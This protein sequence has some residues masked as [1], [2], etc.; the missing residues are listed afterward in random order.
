MKFLNR[1]KD[2]FRN[3]RGVTLVEILLVVALMTILLGIAVPNLIAES[4]EIKMTEMDNNAR[5]VAVAVQSKL[6]GMKN[7]GTT[8]NSSYYKLNNLAA[9]EQKLQTTES[10]D[11]KPVNYVSNFQCDEKE[12]AADRAKYGKSML[13]S[14]AIVDPELLEKGKIVVVY[15]PTT[16]NV[17]EVYYSE[18]EFGV[19]EL[20]PRVKES[21][22]K[23]NKIGLYHGELV[24]EAEKV[25]TM[26]KIE[27]TWLW[28]DELRLEVS[29]R[30][31]LADLIADKPLGMMVYALIPARDGSPEPWEV[32]IYSQGIYKD[33]YQTA[34]VNDAR[35]KTIKA[36]YFAEGKSSAF[37]LRSIYENGGKLRFALD[38]MVVNRAQYDVQQYLRHESAPGVVSAVN[39]ELYPRESISD[40][41]NPQVNPYLTTWFRE[42][43]A[44]TTDPGPIPRGLFDNITG[45][46]PVTDYVKVNEKISLRVELHLLNDAPTF[47]VNTDGAQIYKFNDEPYGY[48]SVQSPLVSPYYYLISENVDEVALSSMRDLNNLHLVFDTGNETIK[49]AKLYADI[50]GDQFFGHLKEVRDELGKVPSVPSGVTGNWT[51]YRL[52]EATSMTAFVLTRPF[53]ISG[54]DPAGGS[55]QI[56]NISFQGR[57]G[58]DGSAEPA[59][60]FEY[61]AGCKFEDI[62]I[63]NPRSWRRNFTSPLTTGENGK[64]TEIHVSG[65]G[66]ESAGGALV[67][68]AVNCSFNN[69]RVYMNNENMIYGNNASSCAVHAS[70]LGGLVGVAIGDNS[71]DTK[72]KQT[73][74]KNCAVSAHC[75]QMSYDPAAEYIYTGGLIGIAMGDVLV[76]KSYAA[77]MLSSYYAGGLIGATVSEGKWSYD[78]GTRYENP[79]YTIE[80]R[81][82]TGTPKITNSFA[83]GQIQREV[84]VGG[85]LIAD[86]R[87]GKPEV[88]GCY[89]SVWWETISPVAYGTFEGD[90]DNYYVYQIR[91]SIP[92]TAN[93]EAWFAGTGDVL[94]LRQKETGTAAGIA[95]SGGDLADFFPEWKMTT[96]D[97]TYQWS[98]DNGGIN[99]R[100]PLR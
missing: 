63:V 53:T 7:A 84:R 61:A 93:V 40:W 4:K 10:E 85:G 99:L 1:L 47:A 36:D 72:I 44:T 70:V 62:D 97:K 8:S 21:Y 19:Q 65:K 13:L 54:T 3:R 32:C 23:E 37:T 91:Y 52:A 80:E 83:A 15:D 6:Y 56:R 28:D 55:Y 90:K 14:G 12:N 46:K 92:V 57:A 9:S 33:D 22:L 18:R 43:G 45:F 81:S 68:F 42:S 89:S 5:A 71:M 51:D 88:T 17:L 79:T 38:S 58:G 96:K 98:Y 20:F 82:V 100:S 35:Y 26:P 30:D 50:S 24:A 34:F 76:D 48:S 87:S 27:C 75:T 77:S 78:N 74:F 73:T 41:F 59:G 67:G 49:G 25:V 86:V 69:V 11:P 29:M 94:S 2:K 39:S 64:I 16:A 31:A 60:M 66:M 95:C